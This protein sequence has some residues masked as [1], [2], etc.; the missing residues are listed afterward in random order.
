M[1]LLIRFPWIAG[2]VL[3]GLA[4]AAVAQEGAAGEPPHRTLLAKADTLVNVKFILKVRMNGHNSEHEGEVTCQLIAPDGLVLCSN[5]ELGGYVTQMS[6][7]GRGI[8]ISAAPSDLE[9]VLPG[10]TEAVKARLLVRDSDRDLAWIRLKEPPGEPLP[11]L[12]FTADATPQVGEKLYTLRRLDKFFGALPIV[13]ESTVGAIA[14]KPR[15]LYVPS[16]SPTVGFGVPVFTADGRLIGVTVLQV[17]SSQ[18]EGV[19][20]RNPYSVVGTSLSMQQMIGG[21]ILPAAEI[22]EATRLA[23]EIAAED[24]EGSESPPGVLTPGVGGYQ[25]PRSRNAQ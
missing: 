18:D 20:F 5:T 7:F 15:R 9:V 25:T 3:V 16:G 10:R 12:D 11:Y 21:L 13:N 6:R 19:N 24:E 23:L 1:Q 14:Q 17:P 2:L 8:S 4:A 22:V